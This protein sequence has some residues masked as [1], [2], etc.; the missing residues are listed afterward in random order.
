MSPAE[1]DLAL[2]LTLAQEAD[3]LTMSGSARW[4]CG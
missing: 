3:S 1:D 2:A 4:I